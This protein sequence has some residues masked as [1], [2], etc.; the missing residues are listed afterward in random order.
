MFIK[1]YVIM[2]FLII[3]I[4]FSTFAGSVL[5][6]QNYKVNTQYNQNVAT[7]SNQLNSVVV[8]PKEIVDRQDG[9]MGANRSHVIRLKKANDIYK[10]LGLEKE[11]VNSIKLGWDKDHR[12]SNAYKII[13]YYLSDEIDGNWKVFNTSIYKAGFYKKIDP[14]KAN[15]VNAV[16]MQSTKPGKYDV[17]LY[18][19]YGTMSLDGWSYG[20]YWDITGINIE[21]EKETTKD[22]YIVETIVIEEETIER[23]DEQYTEPITEQIKE[24]QTEDEVVIGSYEDNPY[25]Y[26]YGA[27][28]EIANDGAELADGDIMN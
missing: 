21:E 27:A 28:E 6:S 23:T 10:T 16:L 1:K 4:S 9:F 15:R 3:S 7:K 22:E 24:E 2:I 11:I 12:P 19:M 25:S 14:L 13:D 5:L 18:G 17:Y 26:R 8:I 20:I